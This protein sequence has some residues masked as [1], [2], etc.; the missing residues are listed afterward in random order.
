M[1]RYSGSSDHVAMNTVNAK[2]VH[3]DFPGTSGLLPRRRLAS[4]PQPHR[5]AARVLRGSA[6]Y[7]SMHPGTSTSHVLGLIQS[8]QAA[9][10]INVYNVLPT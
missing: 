9:R 3:L 10:Q 6:V 5:P 7:C 2:K 1:N 8:V 4:H